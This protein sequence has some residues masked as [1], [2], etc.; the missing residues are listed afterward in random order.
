M[1]RSLS[2]AGVQFGELDLF[3]AFYTGQ[4]DGSVEEV[5]PS[6]RAVAVVNASGH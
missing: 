5:F 3:W 2:W 6:A 4:V 1:Q